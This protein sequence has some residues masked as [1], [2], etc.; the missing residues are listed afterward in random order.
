MGALQA[1]RF[2]GGDWLPVDEVADVARSADERV[3]LLH[4]ELERLR[5]ENDALVQQVEMLRHG[6][7]P[8]AAPQGPDPM[9]IELAVRA[10]EE[11]NRTIDEASAEGAEIIAD[12]RRQAEE[13]VAEAYRRAGGVP[14]TLPDAADSRVEELRLLGRV[15]ELEGRQAAS[16]AALAAAQQQ[17]DRWQAYL[18]GQAEQVR[19]QAAQAAEADRQL[20]HALGG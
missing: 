20:R 10:Q 12:A 13:I 11:A 18:A 4:G 1:R 19:A 3:V 9:V 17:V 14:D 6:A 15:R 2:R 5:R 7:L 8:S 16:A